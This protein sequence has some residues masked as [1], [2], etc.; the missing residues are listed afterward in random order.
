MKK[1]ILVVIAAA[2]LVVGGLS[3]RQYAS[4]QE[5]KKQSREAALFMYPDDPAHPEYADKRKN[6][7]ANFMKATCR[8]FGSNIGT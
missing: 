2:I 3:Y 6:M 5:C 1:I 4:Y 8:K 7:E